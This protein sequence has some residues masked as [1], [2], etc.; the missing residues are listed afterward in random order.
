MGC[1][2]SKNTGGD[3]IKVEKKDIGAL[4]RDPPKIKAKPEAQTPVNVAKE[5]VKEVQVKEEAR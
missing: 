4:M 2:E 3:A 1:S 5:Q